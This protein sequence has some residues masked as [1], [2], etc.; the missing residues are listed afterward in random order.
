MAIELVNGIPCFNC[1]DV[2]RAQKAGVNG[3]SGT[4][5][6]DGV[7]A[8]P[9]SLDTP[10]IAGTSPSTIIKPVSKAQ[11]AI[12]QPLASG[13]RGTVLNLSA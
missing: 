8:A 1:T 10:A 4:A 11:S 12:N 13:D 7:I 2:E 9:S 6:R 3:S 5:T